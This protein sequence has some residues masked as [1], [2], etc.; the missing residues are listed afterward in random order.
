MLLKIEGR[1]NIFFLPGI[2][3]NWEACIVGCQNLK[4]QPSLA[5]ER[6]SESLSH[7][8]P[9]VILNIIQNSNSGFE[10]HARDLSI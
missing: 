1:I 4:F 10:N 6:D 2:I 9:E 5:Y 7:S 3:K 8:F